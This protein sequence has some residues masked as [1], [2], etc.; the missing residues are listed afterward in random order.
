M[1]AE[2]VGVYSLGDY[3]TVDVSAVEKVAVEDVDRFFGSQ[4]YSSPRI[5]AIRVTFVP[6]ENAT[7]G[8]PQKDALI[9]RDIVPTSEWPA[10]I[11][12]TRRSPIV[13]PILPPHSDISP[14]AM[15]TTD[16]EVLVHLLGKDAEEISPIWVRVLTGRRVAVT[17]KLAQ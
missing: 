7:T 1:L 17:L 16:S 6:S 9:S 14:F 12:A 2:R 15:E 3:G 8:A 11:Q 13:R 5:P 4:P 10:L